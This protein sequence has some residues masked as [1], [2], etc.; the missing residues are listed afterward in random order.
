VKSSGKYV[1]PIMHWG[2]RKIK[3]PDNG[4]MSLSQRTVPD[5]V[6]CGICHDLLKKSMLPPCCGESFCANCISNKPLEI[7]CCPHS[8]RKEMGVDSFVP[9]KSMRMAV[10]N[11]TSQSTA[12]GVVG[13][14]MELRNQPPNQRA[15]TRLRI[16]I[17]GGEKGSH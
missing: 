16:A 5:E 15:K 6:K 13:E 10:D 4:E 1:V 9:N 14:W 12:I 2:A 11:W 8:R 17:G 3:R 7:T